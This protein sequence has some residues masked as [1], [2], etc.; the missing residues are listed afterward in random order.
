MTAS[1]PRSRGRGSIVLAMLAIAG[2]GA[3]LATAEMVSRLVV[4]TV[5]LRVPLGFASD[6]DVERRGGMS[7]ED[8]GAVCTFDAE[9][10]RAE[11]T[12]PVFDRTVLFVGDSY[13]Q[14][15]GVVDGASF[16]AQTGRALERRGIHVRTV[17]AGDSGS[18]AAQQVRLLRRL[19]GRLKVDLVVLQICP[20]NDLRDNWEDGGFAVEDGRLVA[21]AP[22]RPPTHVLWSRW[23]ARHDTI[24]SLNVVRFVANALLAVDRYD[25]TD[26]N[27]ALERLL[28][29]DARSASRSAGIPLLLLIADDEKEC[30]EAGADGRPS[31]EHEAYGRMLDLV[32]TIGSP[33]LSSCEVTRDPGHYTVDGHFNEAG[34]ALIGEALAER[35]APLL[36]SEPTPADRRERADS[37]PPAPRRA[38]DG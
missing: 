1:D 12:P 3:G 6:T 36:T 19:L 34:N 25:P 16:A 15:Y 14:G 24:A 31:G 22:P 7:R 11:G 17:N 5:R 21:L 20:H 23:L 28:L 8:G 2:I 13:T 29:E 18:G 9:G 10:F 4:G 30:R 38:N 35:I 26:E 37:D 27:L 33:Y 32:R